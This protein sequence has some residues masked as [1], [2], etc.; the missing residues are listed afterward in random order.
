[1]AWECVAPLTTGIVGVTSVSATTLVARYT[2]KAT[3]ARDPRAEQ[4]RRLADFLSAGSD[5][6]SVVHRRTAG[7]DIT[8][9]HDGAAIRLDL[10]CQLLIVLVPP[11]CV[12]R[13]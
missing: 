4:L 2:S 5:L 13:C 3:E 11:T 9:E 6:I 12:T 1:M 8:R 7:E 10:T